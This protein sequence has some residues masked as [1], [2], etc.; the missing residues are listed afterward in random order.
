M[1][2]DSKQMNVYNQSITVSP[3][4]TLFMTQFEPT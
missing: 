4:S 3:N 1:L 2:G